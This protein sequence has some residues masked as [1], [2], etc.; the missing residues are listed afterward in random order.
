MS[1]IPLSAPLPP[2]HVLDAL[3]GHR[4]LG[5]QRIRIPIMALLLTILQPA[6]L[7]VLEHA[8][9]AAEVP[10][11]ERQIA[12]DALRPVLAVLEGAF[13][14]LRRHAAADG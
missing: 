14:L 9:L 1:P 11:A 10:L 6:A 3:H 8:M 4:P 12:H 2:P 5:I 13:H 7:V